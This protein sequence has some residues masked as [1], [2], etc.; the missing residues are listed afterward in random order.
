VASGD[1]GNGENRKVIVNDKE[2]IVNGPATAA[3][4]DN[5][6][7]INAGAGRRFEIVDPSV[8]AEARVS[9]IIQTDRFIDGGAVSSGT[10]LN[11]QASVGNTLTDILRL[12][13]ETLNTLLS[14]I[15]QIESGSAQ[16]ANSPLDTEAIKEAVR[17]GF[18]E[19][20][21]D[22][23]LKGSIELDGQTLYVAIESTR[24]DLELNQVGG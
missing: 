16:A 7:V 6:E 13:S 21:E 11:L 4:L 23:E 18:S 5:L 14:R 24:R 15:Q 9:S 20:L 8:L 12:Q 1:F 2:F 22:G 10:V 19:A 3:N 17:S